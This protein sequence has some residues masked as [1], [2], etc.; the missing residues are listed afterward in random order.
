MK[1]RVLALLLV[2]AVGSI[3]AD[4]GDP[5]IPSP[6]SRVTIAVTPNFTVPIGAESRNWFAVGGGATLS[7]RFRLPFFPLLYAGM[8]LG[9]SWV[10]IAGVTSMS[11]VQAGASTGIHYDI[12]PA[13]AFRGFGS[14]G[15]SYALLASGAGGGGEPF[16]SAGAELSWSLMPALS[17]AVG[18]KIRYFFDL[19]ADVAGTLGISYNLLE[20]GSR[21]GQPPIQLPEPLETGSKGVTIEKISLESIFPILHIYY[22]SNPIGTLL[23]K[24]RE[25][26]TVT[27]VSVTLIV[28]QFMDAG[29]QCA[30][31]EDLKPGEERRVNLY[32]LFKNN[33]FEIKQSTKVPAE[34]TVSYRLN[35]KLQTLNRV[36]TIRIYDRNA[37]TWD[38]TNK[39]AAFVMPKEPAVLM[40]CH[41][42]R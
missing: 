42:A 16:V 31:L 22:D 23:L 19:Y 35:G 28:R 1:K 41:G 39:A 15:Y 30:V 27:E 12:L 26:G 38:D 18:A 32:A 4:K 24:N 17:L 2:L 13:L 3:Y 37:M 9:Y 5:A 33:V 14:A 25:A 6:T 36:E 34:I 8:D 21:T 20:G 7:G 40:L 10:P 29:K 11:L